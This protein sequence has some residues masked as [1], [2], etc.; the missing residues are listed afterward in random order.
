MKNLRK[1]WGAF[2]VVIYIP[3][4]SLYPGETWT[5]LAQHFSARTPGAGPDGCWMLERDTIFFFQKARFTMCI[6][7]VFVFSTGKPSSTRNVECLEDGCCG[8]PM[9]KWGNDLF[10]QHPWTNSERRLP[11]TLDSFVS[12]S[13][14]KLQGR[15][16]TLP[17]LTTR[18]AAGLRINGLTFAI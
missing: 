16:P 5:P 2:L 9:N 17:T 10:Y 7:N 11:S 14:T 3:T 1:I 15:F 4:S 18:G 12:Q 13:K 6:P 8:K